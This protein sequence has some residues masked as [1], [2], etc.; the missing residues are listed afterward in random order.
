MRTWPLGDSAVPDDEVA[1]EQAGDLPGRRA[2]DGLRERHDRLALI[3]VHLEAAIAPGRV[4]AEAHPVD[5]V[6]WTVEPG[7]A[8][9]NPP[10]GEFAAR[11]GDHRV[12]LGVGPEHVE[13]LAAADAQAA[14]L[15]DR[16]VVMALVLAEAPPPPIDHVARALLETGVTAQELALALTGEE[17]EVLALGTTRHLEPGLR[18]DGAHLGLGQLAQREA[19]AAE[20][21]GTK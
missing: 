14:P 5:P 3:A 19:K 7:A 11:A 10:G 8:N 6:R 15:T 17:A 18:G 9:P 1:V 2:V 16:E 13:R 4:V 21:G 12:G 20:R